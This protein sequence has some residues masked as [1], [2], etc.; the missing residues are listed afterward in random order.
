MGTRLIIPRTGHL[1]ETLFRLV[2]NVLGH[3]GFDKCYE[4]LRTSYYWPN[5]RKDLETG[6]VPSCASCQR[7]KSSTT[8]PLGPLHPLPIPDNRG[9]SVAINFI[10]PLPPDEGY[11]YMVTFTDP[12]GSDIRLVPCQSSITAPELASLF[13]NEWYFENGLPLEIVSDHNKLFISSFWRSLHQLTDTKLKMSTAYYPQTDGASEHT[14]KTV[15]Q[16]L[17]FFVEH[18]QRSWVKSLPIIHFNI[19]N[20]VNKSTGFSPF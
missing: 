16:C 9:D 4:T 3:F 6:Y 10:G 18:N 12:L 20:S 14:N 7:N 5:M 19:M 17:R 15:N 11:D 8:K 2:H 1:R 13:F